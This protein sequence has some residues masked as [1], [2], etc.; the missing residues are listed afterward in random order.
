M[1][2]NVDGGRHI[3]TIVT[4]LVDNVDAS[5]HTWKPWMSDVVLVKPLVE[6]T[7]T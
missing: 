2:V 5:L 6:I 4:S 1:L 7:L 3:G